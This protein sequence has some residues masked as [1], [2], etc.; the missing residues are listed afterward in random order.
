MTVHKEENK[1]MNLKVGVMPGK[2]V[3]V[4]VEEGTSA[5]GIFEIAGVEVNNHEIRL[6]GA[7]INI[8]DAVEEGRLLVAMKMI[9]GNMPS[10]KVG[11]MPGRL[12]IVEYTVGEKAIDIFNRADV[13]V[14]NHE[15]RLDGNKISLEDEINEGNLL[16]AMKMIKGNAKVFN[17]SCTD[18]EIE[19]LLEQALPHELNANDVTYQDDIV[20]VK[21][22]NSEVMID[23]DMFDS[24]Y[25]MKDIPSYN[26]ESEVDWEDE[27]F[28]P[29]ILPEVT[30][31][32]KCECSK[33]KELIKSKLE[34]EEAQYKRWLEVAYEYKSRA[35]MLKEILEQL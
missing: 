10:I 5:R 26:D 6:D 35:D 33:A 7:K 32:E 19:I 1:M 21:V 20:I 2:L 9:K 28:T 13:T 27:L 30:K 29:S 11:I 23:R 34:E 8:D 22:G 15:V 14:S 24:V 18:E 25:E 4:A 17:S 3:E 12:Q 16:V 31:E